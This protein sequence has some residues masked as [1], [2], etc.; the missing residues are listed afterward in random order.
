[1]VHVVEIIEDLSS[2]RGNRLSAGVAG[3]GNRI[4]S[5][6]PGL[7]TADEQQLPPVRHMHDVVAGPTGGQV[8]PVDPQDPVGRAFSDAIRDFRTSYVLR[9]TPEGVPAE[10]WHSIAVS[11]TR[12]GKYDVRA[13]KGY[14]G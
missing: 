9:Y 7:S 5:V 11:V 1:M 6:S 14:G 3:L 8:F 10:G 12:A 13:R 2:L 4:S